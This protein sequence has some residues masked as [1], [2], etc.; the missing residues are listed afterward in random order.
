MTTKESLQSIDRLTEI[1]Q[2]AKQII[3]GLEDFAEGRNYSMYDG[4]PVADIPCPPSPIRTRFL[5]ACLFLGISTLGQL[6]RTPLLTF[7]KQRNIGWHTIQVMK[8]CIKEQYG[9]DWA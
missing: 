3:T 8:D 5:N 4:I 1:M 9:V 2:E 7:R 6:L